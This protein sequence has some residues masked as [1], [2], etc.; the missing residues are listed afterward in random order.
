[1]TDLQ[2]GPESLVLLC[3]WK[4][5]MKISKCVKYP[6]QFDWPNRL[7]KVKH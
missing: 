6:S 3:F 7:L 5:H 1:M 2:I 4:A